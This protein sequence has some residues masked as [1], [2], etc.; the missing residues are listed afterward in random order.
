MVE[1]RLL[2]GATP[3]RPGIDFVFTHRRGHLPHQ[4]DL[5]ATCPHGRYAPLDVH[6]PSTAIDAALPGLALVHQA[7][8]G[9]AC[10]PRRLQLITQEDA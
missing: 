6:A 1:A 3:G 4:W 5:V 2:P 8:V 7:Q 9:C 10:R